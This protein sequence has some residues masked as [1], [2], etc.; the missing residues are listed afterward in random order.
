MIEKYRT[1]LI[2]VVTF[3]IETRGMHYIITMYDINGNQLPVRS[4]TI[5]DEFRYLDESDKDNEVVIIP[6]Y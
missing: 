1:P 2:S 5:G 6:L 4:G 3:N